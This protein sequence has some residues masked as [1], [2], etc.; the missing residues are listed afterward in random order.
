MP[1]AKLWAVRNGLDFFQ[2]P[3]RHGKHLEIICFMILPMQSSIFGKAV[4]SN[5]E[6]PPDFNA[7]GFS[8]P[9]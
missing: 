5:L 1:K 3:P 8:Y 7:V 2:F 6:W 4:L 9:E